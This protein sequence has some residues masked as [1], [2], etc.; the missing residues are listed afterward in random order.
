MGLAWA[1]TPAEGTFP[2]ENGR[3]AFAAENPGF[4]IYTIRADGTGLRR[5]THVPGGGASQPDWSGD[6][7]RIAF[8]RE[9]TDGTSDVIVMDADGSNRHNLTKSGYET[10]PAFSPDDQHLYF[11]CDCHPQGIFVMRDDGTARRRI[12]THGFRGEADSDPN[13]SPDGGTVTFVRHKVDGELQALMAV[14]RTGDNLRR[15]VPYRREVAIKHDWAPD[16]EHIVITINAD[17][18]HGRSPN[19]ATIRSDGTGLRQLTHYAGGRQGAFAGSYSPDGRWI[20]FRV[21][22]L[23]TNVFRLVKMHPDGTHRT[24]IATLPF[25]PRGIDWGPRP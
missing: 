9:R 20:V 12:T 16:G 13:T 15:L 6:G 10:Q 23:K 21:E 4:Q 22:N 1:G 5:V 11:E 8:G 14:D 2:A 24:R 25:A 19:V 18:P 7:T 3:I 17:Y